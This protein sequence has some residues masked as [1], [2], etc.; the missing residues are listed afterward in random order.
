MAKINQCFTIV[1]LLTSMT[2]CTSTNNAKTY[3]RQ[4]NINMFHADYEKAV[5][6][7][8]RAIELDLENTYYYNLKGTAL[9]MLGR[10][11]D[12]LEVYNEAIAIEPENPVLYDGRM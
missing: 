8:G 10:C 7:Y 12:A 1:L 5:D 2:A 9:L 3:F 4:G 6:S 11:E